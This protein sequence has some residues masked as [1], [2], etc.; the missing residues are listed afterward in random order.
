MAD[1]A[2][3]TSLEKRPVW[4]RELFEIAPAT[5]TGYYPCSNSGYDFVGALLAAATDTSWEAMITDQ[6][7]GPPGMTDS[8]FGAPGTFSQFEQP[9]GHVEKNGSLIPADI[10]TP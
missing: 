8:G 2:I 3:G 5:G 10:T 1:S 9:F 4:A 7:F 6:L